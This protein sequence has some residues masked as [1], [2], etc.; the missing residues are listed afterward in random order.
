MIGSCGW[1]PALTWLAF[2]CGHVLEQILQENRS[3]CDYVF[4]DGPPS[5][6]D[7]RPAA[8][9]KVGAMAFPVTAMGQ[10]IDPVNGLRVGL[11][12]NPEAHTFP[13]YRLN[14]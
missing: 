11:R 4:A 12:M 7:D 8:R 3:R 2:G 13:V 14:L 6:P 9:A 10:Q 5:I 1:R